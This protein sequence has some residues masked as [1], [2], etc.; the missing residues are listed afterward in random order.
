MGLGLAAAASMVGR[1]ARAAHDDLARA[2][3]AAWIWSVPLIENARARSGALETLEPGQLF[4][5]RDLTTIATQRVT[6]PNNDTLYSRAWIDLAA[7]PVRLHIPPMGGRYYSAALMDMYAT[8]FA[9]LGSRTLGPGGADVTIV[10][11]D[12]AAA[13][14][15]VRSSTRWCWLLVRI[16][17]GDADDLPNVR[18]LQDRIR[19]TRHAAARPSRPATRD[20]PWDAYFASAQQL[21]AENPPPMRDLGLLRRIA[22]L[23]LGPGQRFDPDRFGAGE[24]A[25]IERGVDAARA[26]VENARRHGLAADGWLYPKSNAGQ[27]ETD[28]VYRA[29]IAISGLGMLPVAEAMYLRALGPDGKVVLPPASGYHLRF[30]PGGAPP[31][32]AF[33]S[34]TMYEAMAD[35]RFFFAANPIDR[36]AIGDRT[37]G[38]KTGADGSLEI[39]IS[40]T[41]PAPE[42]RSN[43]L[44][45]PAGRPFSLVMRIYGPSDG[46]LTGAYRLPPLRRL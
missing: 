11:P 3:E 28:Y 46:L 29:Q 17:V 39:W 24:R 27:F 19:L 40:E 10:G 35:G 8:N 38:L 22:P 12:A 33:W 37:R 21:L 5:N 31:N 6:T 18:A 30:P 4:H 43:W 44:P 26:Q 16:L 41:P 34:L 14:G 25:A 32:Q 1:P 20:A 2:A 15:A 45:A 36:Y 23:G 7:G 42:R 13:P 9:V